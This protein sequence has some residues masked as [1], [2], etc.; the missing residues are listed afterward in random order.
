MKK[1]RAVRIFLVT[2]AATGLT[3]CAT[4]PT[5][6]FSDAVADDLAL[7]DDPVREGDNA[8]RRGDYEAALKSYLLAISSQEQTDPEVWFRVGAVCTHIGRTQQALRAYLEVLKIAPDHAGAL[9]GAGLEYLELKATEEAREH[10][11]AA[12]EVDPDLWRVHNALGILA[13]QE[14]DHASAIGHFAN[15][16]NINVNSPMILNNI[17]FSR[18]LSGDLEQAARD[19]YKATELQ[20]DYQPAWSNL[21][22]VYAR[23]G[24]YADAVSMLGRSV[25]TPVAF[26]NVGFIASENGDLHE[27]EQLLSEAIR[28][29]PTYYKDAYQNLAM[30][31]GRIRTEGVLQRIDPELGLVQN[32]DGASGRTSA[33]EITS[34]GIQ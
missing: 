5:T 19:F 18:Y 8:A 9:E 24:W 13:D 12:I 25:D 27:A 23:Q 33:L 15:A 14:N 17:G 4:T 6:S 34:S 16:L 7:I 30:V 21:G 2:L 11:T 22:L 31:R 32:L 26:N 20:P 1:T 10:L 29:S 3:A 28:L